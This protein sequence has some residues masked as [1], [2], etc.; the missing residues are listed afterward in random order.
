MH[1]PHGSSGRR[2]AYPAL[3]ALLPLLPP[4]TLGK[5][6]HAARVRAYGF[7]LLSWGTARGTLVFMSVLTKHWRQQPPPFLFATAGRDLL[8]AGFVVTL[9]P[10]AVPRFRV[11]RRRRDYCLPP[12]SDS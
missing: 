5:L 2:R 12:L 4:G 10:A 9:S 1:L 11:M 6:V 8:L 3:F 7:F